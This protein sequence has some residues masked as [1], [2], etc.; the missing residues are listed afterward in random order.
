MTVIHTGS[1]QGRVLTDT[2]KF[3]IQSVAG[4][5]LASLVAWFG[6]NNEVFCGTSAAGLISF[7]SKNMNGHESV[8]IEQ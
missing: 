8:L 5:V 3:V 6:K 7:H 1:D 4:L 2:L